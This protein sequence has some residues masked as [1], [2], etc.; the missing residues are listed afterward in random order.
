MA[1]SLAGFESTCV[2]RR[3]AASRRSP[4]IVI[5]RVEDYRHVAFEAD[6][7]RRIKAA[8][9][10]LE[11]HIHDDNRWMQLQHTVRGRHCRIP[12]P[13]YAIAQCFHQHGQSAGEELVVLDDEDLWRLGQNPSLVPYGYQITTKAVRNQTVAKIRSSR[14][15]C[16]PGKNSRL[17][18][19]SCDLNRIM[20]LA[21]S[22]HGL[23][24][25]DRA[26]TLQ[27]FLAVHDPEFPT[28]VY[29][30][31]PDIEFSTRV[32]EAEVSA[33]SPGVSHMTH[34]AAGHKKVAAEHV[35]SQRDQSAVQLRVGDRCR[36]CAPPRPISR[37]VE[38]V[39]A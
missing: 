7:T 26:T 12:H 14:L 13:I 36:V 22:Y 39:L 19:I 21:S 33:H 27:P 9:S 23:I 35:A 31:W 11:V 10:S 25:G 34:N 2:W 5:G 32:L 29:D 37:P 20:S 3:A 38:S 4:P 6:R 8:A 18:P 15:G 30:E 1:S 28:L 24:D 17:E 16:E